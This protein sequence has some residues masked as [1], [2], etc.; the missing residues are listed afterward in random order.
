MDNNRQQSVDEEER[1][2]RNEAEYRKKET[3]V[4]RVVGGQVTRKKSREGDR[5]YVNEE[6]L[7][8]KV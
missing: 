4:C 3:R 1:N 7:S 6:S 5:G 8:L 2:R